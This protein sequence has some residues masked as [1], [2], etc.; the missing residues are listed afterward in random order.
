MLFNLA[1]LLTATN[2][3]CGCLAIVMTALG[4]WQTAFILF[5][6]SLMADALDGVVARK[7]N[8]SGEIGTQLDSLADVITFGLFPAIFL[9]YLLAG[10]GFVAFEYT[11]AFVF[12]YTIGAA[13]RLAVFNVS[14]H[15]TKYFVGLATPAAATLVMGYGLWDKL[16][17]SLLAQ[18]NSKQMIII[19]MVILLAL[20]MH[21]KMPFLSLKEWRNPW[22]KNAYHVILALVSI[23]L[24]LI[25]RWNSIL[26]IVLIYILLSLI[27]FLA[28]PPIFDKD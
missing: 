17:Y 4:E 28:S 23:V 19:A 25:L 20:L 22:H 11:H 16:N 2:L 3:F 10:K 24:L 18:S 7:L 5:F 9:L 27:R 14:G 15:E 21:L 6:I 8:I 26:Y 1:N 13:F 12:I